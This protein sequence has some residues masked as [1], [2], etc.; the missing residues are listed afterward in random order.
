MWIEK[1]L[2]LFVFGI[3]HLRSL[4]CVTSLTAFDEYG[5]MNSVRRGRAHSMERR[6]EEH[7]EAHGL[8]AY[9]QDQHGRAQPDRFDQAASAKD[10]KRRRY[11]GDRRKGAEHPAAQLLRY[12][13]VAD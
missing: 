7:R 10:S 8:R 6:D 4:V 3:L 9:R 5:S 1:Q 13:F 11:L 12:A 2:E